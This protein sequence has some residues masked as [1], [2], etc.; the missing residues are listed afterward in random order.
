MSP[1][2]CWSYDSALGHDGHCCF[3]RDDRDRAINN[4]FKT[5]ANICHVPTTTKDQ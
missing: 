5:D 3:L 1:C 4:G 2:R